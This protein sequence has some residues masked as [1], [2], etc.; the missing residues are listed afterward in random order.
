VEETVVT[1]LLGQSLKR[2]MTD[3]TAAVALFLLKEPKMPL[4]ITLL[5]FV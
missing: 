3:K 5:H 2:V 1:P 4:D